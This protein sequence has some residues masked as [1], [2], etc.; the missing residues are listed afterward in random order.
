MSLPTRVIQSVRP[1]AAP[2]VM[3]AAAVVA[4]TFAATPFLLPDVARRLSID[5]G[6]TGLLSTAQVGSFAVASFLS[7]RVL[8]PRRRLHYGSLALVG[9]ATGV[10]AVAPGFTFLLVTRVAA[11]AGLGLLTWIAWADATRFPRG[12]GEVA[13]VAPITAAL[14]SPPLGWLTEAGGYPLVFASLAILTGLA[15]LAPVDF[16]ALPRIGRQV[17]TSRSN[18]LLLGALMVLSVGGSSVFIFTGAT[19]IEVHGMTPPQV[20]WALSLNALT[21]VIATRAT[22]RRGQAAWWLVGTAASA[23]AVGTT[24]S[25]AAFF[26]ALA[27][28]GFSFWMA[29]PAIFGLLA[30]KS[31]VPSERIGDAQAAMAVGRIFGPVM[32]GI[33]LGASSFDRLSIVGS[34]VIL[35]AASTVAL[36]E[37]HRR[38]LAGG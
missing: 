18:R 20:A 3:A 35:V 32:G 10:S 6:Q 31:N 33:A 13:A 24:A 25:P 9:V 16:G 2:G 8:R 28:W 14:A 11:G 23:L 19:A 30:E 15:M 26:L 38:R 37:A 34:G 27:A 17:S 12:I 22:A 36:I 29:V 1:Q 21:G 7:G 4:A 5:I